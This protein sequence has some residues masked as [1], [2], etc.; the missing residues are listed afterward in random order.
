[1]IANLVGALAEL[2]D[3]APP[4]AISD[5]IKELEWQKEQLA[6]AI[7]RLREDRKPKAGNVISTEHVFRVFKWF[8]RDFPTR[9]AHEQR[10]ILR[11][12]VSRVIVTENGIRLKYYGSPRDEKLL[13]NSPANIEAKLLGEPSVAPN[14]K[15][16]ENP[17]KTTNSGPS[18]EGTGVRLVSDLVGLH[19]F[20]L[21]TSAV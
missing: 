21:W 18:R 14:A 5:K 10:E 3:G 1:M 13:G 8:Q 9:P 2:S 12:V 17:A 7:S 16:V 6:Q 15:S 20:E 11:S 19:R 4:K